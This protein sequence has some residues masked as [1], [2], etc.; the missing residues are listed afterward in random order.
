[1][2]T[3]TIL[4]C[5]PAGAK[6]QAGIGAFVRALKDRTGSGSKRVDVAQQ[7]LPDRTGPVPP[8]A[9]R[10]DQGNLLVN[11]LRQ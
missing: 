11:A 7:L 2:L 8:T 10:Q 4:V 1:M 6:A 5:A 9:D 3:G